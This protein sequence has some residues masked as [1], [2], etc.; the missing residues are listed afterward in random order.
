MDNLEKTILTIGTTVGVTG[1]L[2]Y[3]AYGYYRA[4]KESFMNARPALRMLETN[5]MHTLANTPNAEAEKINDLREAL[6]LLRE[7]NY[8]N[9]DFYLPGEAFTFNR[10]FQLTGKYEI[11]YNENS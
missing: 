3:I 11:S 5:I 6:K 9:R 4:A 10:I 1:F 7:I 2:G 8:E